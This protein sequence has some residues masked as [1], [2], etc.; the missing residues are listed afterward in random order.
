MSVH[1]VHNNQEPPGGEEVADLVF[2]SFAGDGWR[3]ELRVHS[4][5]A[6]IP[7]K[8]L[9]P[10]QKQQSFPIQLVAEVQP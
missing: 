6:N 7:Q 4:V 5:R 10:F 3:S 9:Q 1:V 2:H 8:V